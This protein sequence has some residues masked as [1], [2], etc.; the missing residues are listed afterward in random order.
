MQHIQHVLKKATPR[1]ICSVLPVMKKMENEE[2][3]SSHSSGVYKADKRIDLLFSKFAAFYGHVWRSQFKD[4]VFFVF[5]KKEWQAALKDVSDATLTKAIFYCRDFY[6]LPPTLPQ[7][8]QCCKELSKQPSFYVVKENVA[9]ANQ[10]L[11][12]SC[13]Q[14]CRKYL[15]I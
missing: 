9:P 6:E 12:E 15:G 7:V 5:A 2:T 4:E 1:E 13:L 8:V 11:V 10:A 3:T 14:Q